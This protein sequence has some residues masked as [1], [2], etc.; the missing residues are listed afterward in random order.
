MV[1][2]KTYPI[3]KYKLEPNE[4][5]TLTKF[6]KMWAPFIRFPH[7]YH[8]EDKRSLCL[9]PKA[10][11]IPDDV[12]FLATEKLHG[13]NIGFLFYLDEQGTLQTIIRTRNQFATHPDGRE[14]NNHS[15]VI[16]VSKT[17]FF[18]DD[19]TKGVTELLQSK[20][21]IVMLV[22]FTEYFGEG[23]N[24]G[25]KYGKKR[26]RVFA[27]RTITTDT[28]TLFTEDPEKYQSKLHAHAP[29]LPPDLAQAFSVAWG[30]KFVP[31]YGTFT[32][33]AIPT[34]RRVMDGLIQFSRSE[35]GDLEPEGMVWW[36]LDPFDYR[37]AKSGMR[38]AA[39]K[40]KVCDYFNE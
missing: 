16:N 23:I 15:N 8:E 31:V 38:Y 32:I 2:K 5:L 27:M 13:S 10:H 9:G 6:P 3:G 4:I 30:L 39:F 34:P 11:N 20:K 25:Y 24:K 7:T 33:G 22:I 17:E 18:N 36:A 29:F 21:E 35:E 37:H 26:F 19:L 28:M 40:I 14:V 1:S 12:I